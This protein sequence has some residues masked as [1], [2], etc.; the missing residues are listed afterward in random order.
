MTDSFEVILTHEHTDF[1]AL[2]SLLA[3]S[4]LFPGALPVLPRRLNRNVQSFLENYRDELPFIHPR[5]VPRGQVSRAI[6]VDTNGA[7]LVKGMDDETPRY[8]IDHHSRNTPLPDEWEAWT[9]A[10][11]ANTTML[12]EKLM[13][14]EEALTPVQAT[15]LALGIH[16]DTGSLTYAA[17]TERDANCLAWLLREDHQVDLTTVSRY[18]HFP[19][20]RVQQQLL[21]TL[22]EQTEFLDVGRY[23]VLVAQ[24]EALDFHDEFSALIS[25]MR[26]VYEVDAVF[27]LFQKQKMV[28][29]VARSTTDGIDVG[30]ITRA[31]GGGGHVRA[32]AAPV[33]NQSLPEVRERLI[34]LLRRSQA[35][36]PPVPAFPRSADEPVLV[37]QI[38][39]LGAPQ[40]LPP[41]MTVNDALV[42]MRRYGHE[43]F[44]VVRSAEP[45]HE[46]ETGHTNGKGESAREELAQGAQPQLRPQ[47]QL[48]AA[49]LLG[50]VTRRELDRA[51]D[52]DLG[53]KPIRRFM[54][55]GAVTIRPEQTV[56]E[57]RALITGSGWGQIP[58]VEGT[59]DGSH[60]ELGAHDENNGEPSAE[61]DTRRIIGIVTR[62][63]LI[64]S[65]NQRVQ[66]PYG[67]ETVIRQLGR[68]LSPWH[69]FLLRLLGREAADLGYSTYVV[70]GFVRDILL[71]EDSPRALQLDVDIVM[72][73]DA[74]RYARRIRS[75]YGGRMVEHRRF[76]TANWLL[77][78]DEQP[79]DLE[80]LEQARAAESVAL[81][82]G[83]A[84]EIAE[85]GL[86][87]SDLPVH[88][89]FVTAR[90]EFYTAPTA[91]PTVE[92]GSIKLDLYR[93]DFTINTLAV[94]LNPG[95]WGELLDFYGGLHDLER[96]IVRVL[97]S[98]SF[99]DDPTR[100]LRAVRYEQRFNFRIETRTL[101]LLRD[102][103][104]LLARVSGARIR[105]EL[106]RTLQEDEPE[107]A[108]LRL[109]ELGV[110]ARLHPKLRA[111]PGI[112]PAFERLRAARSGR[113]ESV[114]EVV[115][116]PLRETAV[117]RLYWGLLVYD[118]PAETDEVLV[119][120]LRM[121]RETQRLL[122]GLRTIQQH[123]EELTSD[124]TPPSRH[125]AILERLAPEA[126]AEA[127][128]ASEDEAL[129]TTLVRFLSEWRHVSSLLNG[130]DLQRMN[131]P[132]GP[133]YSHI[134]RSLRDARLDGEVDT[135]AD[136]EA[137]AQQLA[138]EAAE[139]D[140]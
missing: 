76:G 16:E 88:L 36:A 58:V 107:H 38:M 112:V 72:E 40:T 97:H 119:E 123:A 108:L 13:E 35:A 27:L 74:I 84:H 100:I 52:H 77:T 83:A 124:A 114:P 91:L 98:L 87:L 90:T 19:L 44:P 126:L 15:L 46:H 4:M 110:L 67:V 137:L 28:Q 125:V 105:H 3:A 21:H 33:R 9:E 79:L 121:R 50:L 68:M 49:D 23:T 133:V 92:R 128:L 86:H 2:A 117:E 120:R 34:E 70:G 115:Q 104:D 109:D 42:L 25:R 43:G 94:C 131:V 24:A 59:M 12:V 8:V 5:D 14:K 53:N 80:A 93:R 71:N 29:V 41:D 20:S 99:V 103:L 132:R 60:D 63:D 1:D 61:K 7:N 106:D 111:E 81:D 48:R 57:L 6:F 96:G 95:R 102:S 54:R 22:Q 64:R 135:C 73:G 113:D 45:E 55:A 89:D 134:L 66:P 56:D 140:A 139:G 30:K 85:K 18:L 17:T 75:R 129:C 65:G 37:R 127:F 11:G 26:D 138:R 78:D 136:E 47:R 69:Q 116:Q 62:T 82:E 51:Y 10:V 122:A 39:S 118:V 130:N 32:A 31:L 101:E